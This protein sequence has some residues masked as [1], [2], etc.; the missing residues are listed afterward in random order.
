MH[1][2]KQDGH[3]EKEEATTLAGVEE[4]VRV[5]DDS[6]PFDGRKTGLGD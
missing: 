2:V 1:L 3:L 4:K 6:L 5:S